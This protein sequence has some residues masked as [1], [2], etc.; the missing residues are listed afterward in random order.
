MIDWI[1]QDALINKYSDKKDFITSIR[2]KGLLN[3]IECKNSYYANKLHNELLKNNI[4]AGFPK[5]HMVY[6]VS[7]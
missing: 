1:Y 2:G 5:I 3:A 4:F 7:I 6:M